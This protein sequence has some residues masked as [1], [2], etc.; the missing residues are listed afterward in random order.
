MSMHQALRGMFAE[1][2][3]H[4]AERWRLL[5]AC[6]FAFAL[7][8][9]PVVLPLFLVVLMATHLID[10]ST[11]RHRPILRFDWRSPSPWLLSYFLLHLLG[12]LWT[13]NQGFGWFDIGIKLG[14]GVLPLLACMPGARIAGRDAVVVSLVLG[15][16]LSVLLCLLAAMVRFLGADGAGLDEFLSS[17]FSI[18]LH[19]SYLALYLCVMLVTLL[20]GRTGGRLPRAWRLGL[21]VLLSIGIFLSQSRMGWIAMPMVLVWALVSE[22]R[23]AWLRRVLVIT[24]SAGIVGGSSL[25]AISP[26]VRARMADLA[27]AFNSS[28][29]DAEQ[30]AAI[31]TVVWRAAWE[32]GLRELPLGTGTGDVKDELV[33]EYDVMGATHA[34]ERRL[35]AHNQFL[36]AFAALG[37]PGAIALL[38]AFLIPMSVGRTTSVQ[39]MALVVVALNLAVES[40]LEVQAGVLFVAF[41]AWVL[42]LP[43]ASSAS[44]RS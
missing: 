38:L 5:A 25:T 1:V 13:V 4:P 16:A 28:G 39:R 42:W 11:W 22:W 24:L 8:L 10:R 2:G 32:V 7:P 31:R 34:S 21:L 12:M 30:S 17:R 18:F 20:V 15:G 36:Q 27:Q 26:G 9:A 44:S 14:L 3:G 35:N 29:A 23:D 19:P 43:A 40:M 6:L 41:V 33:R 37:I